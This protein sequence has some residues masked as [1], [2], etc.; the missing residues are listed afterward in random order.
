MEF[1]IRLSLLVVTLLLPLWLPMYGCSS[2]H[3]AD[4]ATETTSL[5]QA[6]GISGMTQIDGNSYLV[7]HDALSFE[8]G[9]RMS[10]ITLSANAAPV[11]HPV[12]IDS[13]SH[14]DGR[15]SDLESLCAVPSRS[16]EYLMAESGTWKGKFGRLF[17]LRLDTET[18]KAVILGLIKLPVLADNNPQQVGDQYESLACIKG[19]DGRLLLLLGERGGSQRFPDG[20]IRWGVIDLDRHELVFTKKGL[21]GIKINAPGKWKNERTNRDI[22]D[23]YISPGGELYISAAEDNGDNG[24]FSSVIYSA[25]KISGNFNFPVIADQHPE[26]WRTISSIKIEGLSGPAESVAGSQMSIGS[27]DENYGTIWRPVE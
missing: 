23:I 14:G 25:G 13:W 17:H 18:K 15:A 8:N 4:Q 27:D 22:S 5:P 26:V 9:P 21:E 10:I 16:H 1:K 19:A 24:P 20:V 3:Q 6:A 7:V 12:T 11:F 2:V